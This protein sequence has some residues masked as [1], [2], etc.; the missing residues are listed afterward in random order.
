[1]KIFS[2]EISNQWSW[3][4]VMDE[5]AKLL[6]YDFCRFSDFNANQR[7]LIKEKSTPVLVQNIPSIQ[8]IP[9]SERV[10]SRMGSMRS[11]RGNTAEIKNVFAVIATNNELYKIG[12]NLNPNTYLIP[13][14][15][16]LYKFK[17][18]KNKHPFI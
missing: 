14:G 15:V 5:L 13:N 17:P 12:K 3:S 18:I 10:I 8:Y 16:D 11:L 9:H 4:F 1:M 7:I 2:A 6:P